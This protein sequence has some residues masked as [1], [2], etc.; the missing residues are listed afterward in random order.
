MMSAVDLG[1]IREPPTPF[2]ASPLV[3]HAV[4]VL[5]RLPADMR[6][7]Q[8]GQVDNSVAE[9]LFHNYAGISVDTV[10]ATCEVLGR[11]YHREAKQ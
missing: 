1:R 7:A 4:Q 3:P 5:D 8:V 6:P 9:H 2:V 10:A 11:T